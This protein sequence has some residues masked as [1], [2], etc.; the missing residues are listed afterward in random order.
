MG[1]LRA[2]VRLDAFLQLRSGFYYAAV[3]VTL[4]W[5]ALLYRCPP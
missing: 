3:F 2:T 1:R 4:V 5:V